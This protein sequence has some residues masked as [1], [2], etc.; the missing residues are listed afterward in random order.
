[1]GAKQG[2]D[3]L[4]AVA[5]RFN[6]TP[7]L[8]HRIYFIFCG[9][10]AGKKELLRQCENLENVLFL[11]LQPAENLISFL[12]L[13]DI[14]LLPQR[15]DVADLVMPSKLTGMLASSRPIIASSDPDTELASAVGQC[16]LIVPP[17]DPMAFYDALAR[18]IEDPVLRASLGCLARTY[19]E[20]NLD[21]SVILSKFEA[22]IKGMCKYV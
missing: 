22:R 21:K 6:D 20:K 5:Q 14:H 9:N 10:G 12:S 1:M 15:S 19:A 11:D 16:G 3:V 7:L 8:R 13:A 17:E 4:G 2:L 18:L